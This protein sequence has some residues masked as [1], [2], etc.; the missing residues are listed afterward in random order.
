ME[1]D[2]NRRDNLRFA[3][4]VP[5]GESK[6]LTHEINDPATIEG[7]DVRIYRGAE[8]D[9]QLVPFARFG[10]DDAPKTPLVTLIGKDYIDGD[11]DEFNFTLSESVTPGDVVG[12]EVEN[13]STEFD[14]DFAVDMDLDHEGGAT[15]SATSILGRLFS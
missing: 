1:N 10:G 2:T 8:L 15:R 12:V 11:G 9:L 6:E 5:A 3:T 7:V 13:V 4:G 14:Y